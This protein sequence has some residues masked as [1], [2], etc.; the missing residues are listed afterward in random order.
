MR[1]RYPIP[2]LTAVGAVSLLLSACGSA[3]QQ[4]P[5]TI[6]TP[7]Q[8]STGQQVSVAEEPGITCPA[9]GSD[10]LKEGYRSYTSETREP[11]TC[12]YDKLSFETGV[13]LTSTEYTCSDCGKAWVQGQRY[14]LSRCPAHGNIAE[15]YESFVQSEQ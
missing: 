13:V 1:G 5:T 3:G 8:E 10:D 14:I 4:E 11:E 2:L 12:P 6:A 7:S 15:G 9:C